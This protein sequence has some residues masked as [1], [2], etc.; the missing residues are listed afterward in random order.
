[1]NILGRLSIQISE[2]TISKNTNSINIKNYIIVGKIN[3]NQCKSSKIY[4]IVY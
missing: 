1:M 3:D 2:L 4:K